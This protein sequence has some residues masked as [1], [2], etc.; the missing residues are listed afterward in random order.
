MDPD[1]S[2]YTRPIFI[3]EPVPDL[4]TPYQLIN[5]TN[6]LP[7]IDVLSPN[8]S[9]LAGFMGDDGL[10]P[11]TRRISQ[12]SVE[13]ACEQ[14]LGSMPLS[15]FTIVVR[16]GE[17]G[18]YIC[19]PGGRK[20]R[21]GKGGD[22]KRRKKAVATTGL[23]GLQPDTD[24]EALFAGLVQEDGA[25]AEEE[26]EFDDAFEE[27]I[28]ASHDGPAKVVDPT[29]AGNAFLGGL[30][31]A[32]ARGESIRDAA[33]WGN[34]A[35]SFTVEQVGVPYLDEHEEGEETWNGF[36]VQRRLREYKQRLNWNRQSGI[37]R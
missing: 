6:T 14:L 35:A 25:V 32:L 1:S 28:P 10:D 20:K 30:G 24:M 33:I 26:I 23:H 4:C 3:W 16:A 18:C 37:T 34:V 7:L 27:W 17:K 9:E 19:K 8:H 36:E 15:T 12:S 11:V 22:S 5:L 13:R 2:S 29:G 31:V 21:T